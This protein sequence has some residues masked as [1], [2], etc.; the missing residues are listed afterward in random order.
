MS[1]IPDPYLSSD[2]S[3]LV[4]R[5]IDYR[6]CTITLIF[7]YFE[8]DP[9]VKVRDVTGPGLKFHLHSERSSLQ[10]RW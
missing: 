9:T 8:K 4:Q 3:E 6:S 1:L 2:H 5:Y 7:I 10:I